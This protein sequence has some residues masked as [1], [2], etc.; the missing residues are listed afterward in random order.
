MEQFA[1]DVADE[2]HQLAGVAKQCLLLVELLNP[3][4]ECPQQCFEASRPPLTVGLVRHD[5]TRFPGSPARDALCRRV[6]SETM[7]VHAVR[8]QRE[9]ASR[10]RADLTAA[11]R[12]ESIM[13]ARTVHYLPAAPLLRRLQSPI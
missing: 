13:R 1:A 8:K 9:R 7:T 10:G 3:Q 5:A 6:A 2:P 4:R 12:Q 11:A